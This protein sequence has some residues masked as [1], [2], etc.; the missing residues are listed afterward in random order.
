MR[1]P[2]LAE[3][4]LNQVDGV[5]WGVGDAVAAAAAAMV[6]V[7]ALEDALRRRDLEACVVQHGVIFEWHV[8]AR[9]DMG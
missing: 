5:R 7:A 2:P 3:Q 8:R 4:L 6:H 1:H 9:W